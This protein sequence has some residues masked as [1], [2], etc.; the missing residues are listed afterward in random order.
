MLTVRVSDRPIESLRTTPRVERLRQELLD[1]P[2]TETD[3]LAT[4]AR[5]EYEAHAGEP[6]VL[7]R[8]YAFA[9]QLRE[10][11][12]YVRGGELLV[13]NRTPALCAQN[14]VPRQW[15]AARNDPRTG[16]SIM[17]YE[18]AEVYPEFLRHLTPEMLAAQEELLSG[19]P[20]GSA[21]GF[22]HII[23]GYD[24]LIEEGAAAIARRARKAWEETP[25]EQAEARDSRLAMAI[26]WEAFAD[27]GGRYAQMLAEMA[28][29]EAD[30]AR[31]AELIQM[32]DTLRRVPARRP[33]NFR[34]ALQALTLMQFAVLLEQPNGGSISMGGIDRTLY[35]LLRADLDAGRLSWAEA[36]EL[37]DSFYV[38]LMENAI[39]PR[40]VV[41]FAN[42]SIG[43]R[44][45]DAA[46]AVNDLSLIFLES[47]ARI[48]STHPMLSVRWHPGIDPA[49]F[50]RVCE[51]LRMG[52]GLPA[53]FSDPIYEAVLEEWGLS[54][55]EAARYGIV[56]CVEPAVMGLVHGQT[57]G[58]HVNLLM[59][60][61]LAMNDGRTLL[62]D[63]Q[64][65]PRTGRF[66][67]FESMEA[68]WEA[69]TRQVEHACRVNAEA[70]NAVDAAQRKCYGYPFM[71]ASMA[72]AIEA[73]RDISRGVRVNMP[74]VCMVGVSN[75][76]DAM[77]AV[78]EV[79]FNRRRFAAGALMEALRS[80]YEGYEVLRRAL[81][82]VG[83]KFGNGSER[84]VACFN[85]LSEIQQTA[86]DRYA[87]PRGGR[88][89][90][91]LWATTWHVRM[92][93]KTGASA[94]GRHARE[95]LVDGIGAVTGRAHNGP[96]AVALDVAGI[97]AER[98][99][100]GGY[101]FNL[102]FNKALLSGP[103]GV[104]RLGAFVDA[105]FRE[106]G[107]QL[108]I[109]TIDRDTL[110][111]AQRDPEH[112]ADLIVRVAGFSAYFCALDRGVQDEIISR[113]EHAL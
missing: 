111:E 47:T 7:R 95:P 58:G 44:D 101:T 80:D 41:M 107:M 102:K 6:A 67:D 54:H 15:W 99:W 53:L 108:Q 43:G 57:L 77:L 61:E 5:R 62:T 11:P 19:Y 97:D 23:A 42:L 33:E 21:G 106:R 66:E 87:G 81:L 39:W 32:R 82:N 31:R 86:L 60:L 14:V 38:K 52:M 16:S 9:A 26:A 25:A 27:W 113:A 85:R 92:G 104:R 36:E 49:F 13:G 74:T 103:D 83:E 110:I 18:A 35:P 55:E 91:G 34:E 76:A 89:T 72:G 28:E 37:V 3:A 4:I 109:N 8:A 29:A 73:G 51:L 46:D 56:G 2:H 98:L 40:E 105:F 94:D 100:Q 45:A 59:C 30:P 75:V 1:A 71:S 17:Q 90:S 22:G 78:E 20:A 63:R 79:I 48:R 93:E 112:H 96:T 84:A 12:L 10:M 70:V 69:Y 68:L 24:M 50:G 64:L 65:G 88:L